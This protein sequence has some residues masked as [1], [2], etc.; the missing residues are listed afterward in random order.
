MSYEETLFEA[1][2]LKEK[3]HHSEAISLC[4]EVLFEDPQN[5]IALEEVG[6]NYLSL[7]QIKK[8]K[9]ALIAAAKLEP[10]SVNANYLLGFIFSLE[11][12]WSLSVR[13]LERAEK[14]AKNNP[15][16]LRSLGWSLFNLGQQKEGIILLERVKNMTPNDSFLLCDLGVCYML[17]EKYAKALNLF[18][19]AKKFDPDNQKVQDC[20]RIAQI[21]KNKV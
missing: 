16:I 3:G 10:E 9:R 1:E 21:F 6:D 11:Q 15:E 12:K 2:K 4:E 20:I 8:A 18:L 13:C 17:R 5:V 14:N 19:V 7:G